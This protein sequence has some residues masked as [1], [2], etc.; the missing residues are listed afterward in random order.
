VKDRQGEVVTIDG[1]PVI[2]KVLAKKGRKPREC[3]LC[4]FNRWCVNDTCFIVSNSQ[5]GGMEWLC[6]DCA[7][8]ERGLP[9]EFYRRNKYAPP[10]KSPLRAVAAAA[11]ATFGVNMDDSTTRKSPS[12]ALL[13][14]WRKV[15]S[16]YF[17]SFQDC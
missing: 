11:A 5:Q 10:P 12:S 17:C 6:P 4:K 7:V 9:R 16:G 8:D 13:L 3:Q 1:S 15:S 2:I 14:D